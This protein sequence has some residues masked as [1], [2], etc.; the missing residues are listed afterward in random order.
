MIYA[1]EI[2]GRDPV[3]IGFA[4]DGL[5]VLGRLATATTWSLDE[6]R[7]VKVIEGTIQQEHALHRRAVRLRIKGEWFERMVL[8]LM[9]GKELPIPV[10]SCSGCGAN[11]RWITRTHAGNCS[12]CRDERGRAFG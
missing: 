8:E 6:V 12:R 11:L 10:A 7:I 9:A 4:R 2:V 1:I 3:K 5:A